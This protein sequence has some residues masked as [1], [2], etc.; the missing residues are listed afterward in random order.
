[1]YSEEFNEDRTSAVAKSIEMGVNRVLLPNIDMDS[2]GV[3]HDLEDQYLENCFSMMGLHPCY[4]KED[5][6][7]DLEV[8]YAWFDKRKYVGV[9]ETGMDLYW[10]KSTQAWQEESLNIQIEWAIEKGLAMSLHTRNATQEV[11]KVLKPYKGKVQGVF[12]CFSESKELADEII[13]LGFYLGIGGVVTFKN[14]GIAQVV[15]ELGI[16]KLV[17]ETDSPYLAPVPYRGKRNEPSYTRYV[18]ENV[19]DVTGESLLKVAEA[20]SRNAEQL[21]GV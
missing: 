15:A 11:I 18:A 16:E 4:V 7:K 3:M 1:L 5:F 8:M 6:K 19:A 21:F 2:I 9:G 13:K 17:L 20:T 12:H 10:D 14:A